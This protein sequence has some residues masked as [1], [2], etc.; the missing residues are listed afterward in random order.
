M[1][2]KETLILFLYIILGFAMQGQ[3]LPP[4]INCIANDTIF[5][6]PVSN[7]CGAFLS[8][9]IFTSDNLS[10]PYSQLTSVTDETLTSVP[11]PN[12]SNQIIYY[13]I[14]PIYDCPSEEVINSDTVSNRP[15]EDA[16]LQTVSV[17]GTDI[18]LTWS[19]SPSPEADFYTVFLITD[20]GLE[21]VA[22]VNGLSYL[23]AL[24]DPTQKSF[25][26]LLVATDK[27][28]NQSIFG[29]AKSS[30]LLDIDSAPCTESINFSW[31]RHINATSQELW[32]NSN[33]GTE[34]KLNDLPADTENF[35][36]N[37][38]PNIVLN[39][40]FIKSII[41]NNNIFEARSNVTQPIN[42]ISIA[43]D[44]IFITD[45]NTIDE[46][47]LQLEWCWN[48]NADLN[49]YVVNYNSPTLNDSEE[50]PIIG[51]LTAT[52]S[53]QVN[54][55]NTNT[56]SYNLN[57][58]STDE[59]DRTFTSGEITSIQLSSVPEDEFTNKITWNEFNYADA[60]FEKY[61]L[62]EVKSGNNEVIYEGVNNFFSVKISEQTGESCYYVEA[63]AS[64]ILEDGSAKNV[65]IIS[66]TSCSKGFPIVRFP[67]AFNPYGVNKIFKPLIG[68][69]DAITGY[70]MSVFS[71]YGELLYITKNLSQG[72]SGKSGLREMP[73]GVYVYLA[74]VD[75]LGGERIVIRGSVLLV[76]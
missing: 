69:I 42:D 22:D 5:Y 40:F 35:V 53:E 55:N 36:L 38:I 27:C 66:N 39:G 25:S 8:Y 11:H 33:G 9:D 54:V 67:N 48:E 52:S 6:T 1:K 65:K 41:D 43:M 76:R 18:L 21:F 20:S 28:G 64:G 12:S 45:V 68:N 26:Y 34:V 49:K 15:P 3:V 61:I 47:T 13:Y 72:W 19:F 46:N 75:V 70:E 57:I 23:D 31:N 24:R 2:R 59:C 60:A 17:D 58:M 29:E 32:A 7:P 30:I 37:D 63:I 4:D 16:I 56:E 14:V 62:H 44:E 10:G 71:R 73:Q 74:K 50:Q 51:N